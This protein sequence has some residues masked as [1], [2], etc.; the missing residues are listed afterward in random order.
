MVLCHIKMRVRSVGVTRESDRGCSA[1]SA[2]Y[3][4]QDS[5]LREIL[6]DLMLFCRKVFLPEKNGKGNNT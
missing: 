3:I 2:W 6:R 5:M 4:R 1:Q